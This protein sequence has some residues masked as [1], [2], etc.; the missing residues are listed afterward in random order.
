MDRLPFKP[1]QLSTDFHDL[2]KFRSMD[3]LAYSASVRPTSTMIIASRI[4]CHLWAKSIFLI[5]SPIIRKM[6]EL[7]I[8]VMTSQN[9]LMFISVVSDMPIFAP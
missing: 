9:E 1:P 3:T 8:K 2:G 7:A 6:S 4:I 5:S